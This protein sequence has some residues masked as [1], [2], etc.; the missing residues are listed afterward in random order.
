MAGKVHRIGDIGSSSEKDF[1]R[2][3]NEWVLGQGSDEDQL[4][5]ILNSFEQA[6]LYAEGLNDVVMEAWGMLIDGKI[7]KA[8]FESKDDVI[9]AIDTPF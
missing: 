9:K 7:W 5:G 3:T 8:K 2:L 4:N 1:R 6:G